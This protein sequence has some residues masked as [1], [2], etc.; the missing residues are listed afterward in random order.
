MEK[1]IFGTGL[2]RYEVNDNGAIFSFNPTDIN[3]YARFLKLR[4][5]ILEIGAEIEKKAEELDANEEKNVEEFALAMEEADKKAKAML[6]ECFGKSNDFELIFDG[7]NIFSATVSGDWLITEFVTA[8]TPI[9]EKEV[10]NITK[11]KAKRK[12]AQVKQNKAKRN[13]K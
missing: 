9:I 4:D 10:A 12:A 2:K 11:E 5:N 7:S 1:L 13:G 3:L 6:T 8:I